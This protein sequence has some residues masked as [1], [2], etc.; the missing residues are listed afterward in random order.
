MWC[1]YTAR[2]IS[3]L[4][5]EQR[6]VGMLV[7]PAMDWNIWRQLLWYL[8]W[9]RPVLPIFTILNW[10]VAEPT[11]CDA[12]SLKGCTRSKQSNASYPVNR[13][14]PLSISKG[15]VNA[16]AY[17]GCESRYLCTYMAAIEELAKAGYANSCKC[18]FANSLDH[19]ATPELSPT[20]KSLRLALINNHTGKF[21]SMTAAIHNVL[22]GSD[23]ELGCLLEQTCIAQWNVPSVK[24][25]HTREQMNKIWSHAAIPRLS[26]EGL[27]ATRIRIFSGWLYT[28]CWSPAVPKKTMSE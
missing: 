11:S 17:C 15:P 13:T 22:L 5:C 28:T 10:T 26:W 9:Q 18:W 24:W 16:L 8:D 3:F 2:L 6:L 19:H 1:G 20:N 27:W 14:D 4:S 12:C 23:W 25:Y 7:H 21:L